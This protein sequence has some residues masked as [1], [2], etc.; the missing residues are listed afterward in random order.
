MIDMGH[1]IKVYSCEF[2]PIDFS[3]EVTRCNFSEVGGL[4]CKARYTI[5]LF[6]DIALK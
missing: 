4:F 3:G 2:N 1:S 6:H 5:V